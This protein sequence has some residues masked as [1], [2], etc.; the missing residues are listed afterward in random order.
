MT[1]FS[2][3]LL[4]TAASLFTLAACTS[5]SQISLDYAS[6]AGHVQ[7]GTPEFV[8]QAFVDRRETGTHDLGT[9]RTQLGTP[10]E[11]LQTRV[12]VA[13]LVTN[14]FGYALQTRGML[15]Q[16]SSARYIVTGE[17]LELQCKLLVHPYGYARR[18]RVLDAATGSVM[19]TGTYEGERQ[20]PA[21]VP[22][23]GSPVPLL[24]DLTS[25]ALQ[26]AVDRALDDSAM[27]ARLQTRPN[28]TSDWQP[29]M[30]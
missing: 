1:T 19:H 13:D 22:G 7:L 30:I 27:R 3:R 8:T 29:G 4:T 15:A 12:P 14:A 9:V 24:T 5:T 17:V 2:L 21:Y 23:S 25:G 20:S 6:S 28:Q 11:H 16:R 26:D 18:V 10:L